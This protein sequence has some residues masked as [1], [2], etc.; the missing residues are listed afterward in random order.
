VPPW[1]TRSYVRDRFFEPK[2]TAEE[3]AARIRQRDAD[4]AAH[5]GNHV[6][7]VRVLLRAP[8]SPSTTASPPPWTAFPRASARSDYARVANELVDKMR[9]YAHL[10]T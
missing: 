9:R 5:V 1:G 6:V 10:P 4:V 8:Q 7:E 3:V 2:L